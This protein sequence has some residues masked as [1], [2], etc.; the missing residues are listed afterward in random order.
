MSARYRSLS[1]QLRETVR[2]LR[3]DGRG[4]LLVT[5]AIG[6]AFTLGMRFI[7]PTLLPQIESNLHISDSLAGLAITALWIGYALM[8][9]PA[10]VLVNRLGERR[11]LTASLG[12]S[13]FSMLLLGFAPAFGVFFLGSAAYGLTSGLYG[14]SRGTVL[15]RTFTRNAGA[16]FGITLAIGSLGSA[17]LPNIAAAVVTDVGWR[18]ILA[19]LAVPFFVMAVMA[20]N[21]VPERPAEDDRRSDDPSETDAVSDGGE[22]DTAS[23]STLPEF[24]ELVGTLSDRSILLATLSVAILLFAYQGIT[25]FLPTY[26]QTKGLS[27]GTAA[28][29]FGFMFVVGAASQIVAGSAADRIG[30]KPVLL[31]VTAIGVVAPIALTLVSGKLAIAVVVGIL[32]T[33]MAVN[34]VTNSFIV[35]ALPDHLQGSAWGFIRTGFFLVGSLGSTF[36]GV[37]ADANELNLA[38]II[39]GVLSAMALGLY[40]LLPNE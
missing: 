33:R 2:G 3:G 28:L 24:G 36:M 37:F 29:L 4:W 21:V 40:A 26:L 15:S 9:F 13:G 7:L 18:A 25:A 8:Q 10:G 16:A 30:I 12:L 1:R 23:S 5:V 34:A 32:G 19:G 17:F 14:P 6:W 22:S 31:V 20:W 27:Q 11:L 38:F 39:L 35:G